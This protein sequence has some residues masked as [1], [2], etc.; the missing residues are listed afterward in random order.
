MNIVAVIS[1]DILQANI[2]VQGAKEATVE[3]TVARFLILTLR[4]D[5]RF[6]K[7]FFLRIFTDPKM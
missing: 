6:A 3:I 4:L 2:Y 1:F 7:T 5:V